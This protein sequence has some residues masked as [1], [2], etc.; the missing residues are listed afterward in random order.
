VAGVGEVSISA[1]LTE[2]A[3]RDPGAVA[4]R[5]VDPDD[6]TR[7]REHLTRAALDRDATGTARALLERGPIGVDDRVVVAVANTA[8]SVVLLLAL[9]RLGATPVIVAPD[10]DPAARRAVAAAAGAVREV[11]DGDVVRGAAAGEP[12]PDRAASAW[13]AVT[14]GG[15]TGTPKVVLSLG[16][17]V[18]DPDRAV[19]PYLPTGQVQLVAGRLHD[20]A[21]F[22][23]ALR[24]LMTGHELVVLARPDPAAALA[25]IAAHR[26][27]WTVLAPS[28]MQR[29][30]RLPGFAGADLSSLAM[31][32]HLGA[33]CPPALKRTWIARLGPERV[34]EVYASSE[35][36]GI[37]MIRGDEWLAHPGSVG[38]G[39]GGST[40]RV[41]GPDGR[42][43]GPGEVGAVV[44]TR[45]GG[46]RYRYLGGT[47]EAADR[48]GAAGGGTGAPPGWT[49]LGDLGWLDEQGW[50]HLV[51]RADDVLTVDGA[52]VYPA[53]VEAVLESHPAVRSAAV[54]A[55]PGGR[56]HALLDLG[57]DAGRRHGAGTTG[58]A[59][60]AAVADRLS[61][62]ERPVAV[63]AVAG[64]L[65]DEAGKLNRRRLAR[66]LV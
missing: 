4:V 17:A 30:A 51:D 53:R 32:V 10:A 7:T 16:A 13:K 24:G 43:R 3:R 62:R 20:S 36:A 23:Y 11:D 40:F 59:V 54:V 65:R 56:P 48:D 46:P 1:A 44:M 50:L 34:V 33:P 45:P 38:R 57:V 37:T 41:L 21:P 49:G 31:L 22:T 29:I 66:D 39:I 9:W 47:G 28:T 35:S 2:L 58:E 64:P 61:A 19:A 5:V 6:A 42:D 55:G 27:S 8:A 25:A 52:A 15:S 60:L 63:R 18:V 14:S 12:L 26:V